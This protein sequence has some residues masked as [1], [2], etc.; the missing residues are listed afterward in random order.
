MDPNLGSTIWKWKP[1]NK[2]GSQFGIQFWIIPVGAPAAPCLDPE[3]L[4]FCVGLIAGIYILVLVPWNQSSELTFVDSCCVVQA[5]AV[6]RG[7]GPNFGRK[8]AQNRRKVKYRF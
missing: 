2:L 7:P 4:V 8:P 5:G 3:G 1:G 6:R